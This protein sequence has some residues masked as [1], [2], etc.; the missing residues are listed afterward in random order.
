VFQVEWWPF[1]QAVARARNG[2]L[3]D[4]KTIIGILRAEARK[5]IA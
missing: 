5:R 3:N 4:A 1:A 2:E